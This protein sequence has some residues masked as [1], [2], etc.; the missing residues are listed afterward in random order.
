ME[1]QAKEKLDIK[2]DNGE[3]ATSTIPSDFTEPE[4]LYQTLI[5]MV[6]RYH[7]SDD[8]HLIEKAYRSA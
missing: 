5:E 6:K 4:E 2:I 3:L 1:E 8:I 7:P